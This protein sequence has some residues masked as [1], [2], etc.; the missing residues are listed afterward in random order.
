M[1]ATGL[2][3]TPDEAGVVREANS[4]TK[5]L[6][7]GAWSEVLETKARKGKKR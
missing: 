3:A 7:E 1:L 2:G 6:Y 5:L 4:R